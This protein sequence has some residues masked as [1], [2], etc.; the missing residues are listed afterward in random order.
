M[1]LVKEFYKLMDKELVEKCLEVLSPNDKF[2]PDE[3]EAIGDALPVIIPIIRKSV[4]KE[5]R[6]EWRQKCAGLV[7]TRH[8]ISTMEAR[9]A[10]EE[11]LGAENSRLVEVA[12][13]AGKA[14]GFKDGQEKIRREITEIMREAPDLRSLERAIADWLGEP[15]E[16][17]D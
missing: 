6:N 13:A 14:D 16:K 17:K 2:P 8:E 5:V 15:I 1:A 4:E 11:E 12:R 9:K 7:A 3:V 10:V